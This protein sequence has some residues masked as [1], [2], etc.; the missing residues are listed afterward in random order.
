MQI[1]GVKAV[2]PLN[3][4]DLYQPAVYSGSILKL[5]YATGK[6]LKP[7]LDL[8]AAQGEVFVQFWLK[9]GDPPV[10]FE[11]GRDKPV[12]RI[13]AELKAVLGEMRKVG[14]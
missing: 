11:P 4:I 2:V 14:R 12:E 13:P 5:H 10:T 1:A 3:N 9:P 7:W 8:T 6:E